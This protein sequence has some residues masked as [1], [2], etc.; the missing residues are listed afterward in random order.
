[1]KTS[2]YTSKRRWDGAVEKLSEKYQIYAPVE[3]WGH[4]DYKLIGTA[5]VDGIVYNKARPTTP[6]KSFLLPMRENVSN[7]LSETKK[8]I[9][10]A[11]NCDLKALEILDCMYLSN[12]FVDPAYKLNR[13]NMTIISTD[14]YQS[15]APLSLYNVWVESFSR[16]WG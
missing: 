3:S 4:L 2:Q 12:D 6:L 13:K 5:D 16:K 14:C 15:K 9:I 7:L 11:P 10:G 1:M 8:I